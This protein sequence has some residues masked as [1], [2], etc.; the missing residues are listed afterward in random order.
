V[1]E[2]G[3]KPQQRVEHLGETYQEIIDANGPGTHEMED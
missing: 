2:L 1:E 3:A